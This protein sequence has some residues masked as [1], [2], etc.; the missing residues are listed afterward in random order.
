VP[1]VLI[2]PCFRRSHS[3][4][5]TSCHTRIASPL[6]TTTQLSSHL[7]RRSPW[8]VR[9]SSH[10]QLLPDTLRPIHRWQNTTLTT[11]VT[12]EPE[13]SSPH[14]NIPPPVPVL[15]QLR[16]APHSCGNYN[17]TIV[18]S[19]K[20][21]RCSVTSHELGRKQSGEMKLRAGCILGMQFITYLASKHPLVVLS[22]IATDK[23]RLTCNTPTNIKI[24]YKNTLIKHYWSCSELS[25][26]KYCRVKWSSLMMEA[27]RTY[28]TS[29]D[30][31]FTRQYIPEDNSDHTRRRDNLKSHTAFLVC[32]TRHPALTCKLNNG[33]NFNLFHC[34]INQENISPTRVQIKKHSG[35]LT[36]VIIC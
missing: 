25:S 5:P 34:E 3:A 2:R 22:Q 20:L 11:S 33:L 1:R 12:S 6:H 10:F 7:S 18:D 16:N 28:E 30:N 24:Y 17:I 19:E 14:Y 26:G 36:N 31:H 27:V 13:G 32:L 21:C 35:H 15:S 4:R 29:V 9:T 8:T 23:F